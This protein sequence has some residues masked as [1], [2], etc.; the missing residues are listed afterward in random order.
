MLQKSVIPSV[1]MEVVDLLTTDSSM[2]WVVTLAEIA[3]IA[4][5][6]HVSIKTR[7]YVTIE[8]IYIYIVASGDQQL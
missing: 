1:E 8:I 4:Q 6:L 5:V 2:G 3:A 7:L